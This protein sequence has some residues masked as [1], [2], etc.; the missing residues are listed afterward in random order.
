MF[1]RAS[2]LLG[3]LCLPASLVVHLVSVLLMSRENS[4]SLVERPDEGGG[5]GMRQNWEAKEK[6]N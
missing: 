5:L 4:R 2:K 3:F 1:L 6:S